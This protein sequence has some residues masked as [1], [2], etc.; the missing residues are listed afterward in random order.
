MCIAQKVRLRWAPCESVP[1]FPLHVDAMA[2]RCRGT[3]RAGKPCSITATS[4]LTNDAGRTAGEP[5][6]RGSEYCLFHAKPFH[7]QPVESELGEC[8]VVLI[9]LETSGVDIA[10]DRTLEL[11]AVHCPSDARFCGSCFSTV[12]RVD[13]STLEERGA[14]AFTVH[15]IANEEIAAGPDFPVAWRRFLAWVDDLLNMATAETDDSDDDEQRVPQLQPDPPVLLLA[16]H[17]ALRFDFPLLLS[18]CLRHCLPCDC[19]EQWLFVDTLHVAQ[20]LAPHGCGKLQCLVKLG[21]DPADLRAHRALRPQFS[22]S[23]FVYAFVHMPADLCTR[24]TARE[25]LRLDD[26][27]ALRHVAVAWAEGLGTTLPTLLRRFAV[28]LDLGTSIAQTSLLMD[29]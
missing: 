13:A 1:S 9:D 14:A 27:V 8:V 24:S 19:F 4:L 18:E 15:G 29:A 2:R 3:T 16:G 6:K 11:G 17:N 20:A 12:V 25:N 26:C 28:R 22:S 5:L 21:G 23:F 7:T 10:R